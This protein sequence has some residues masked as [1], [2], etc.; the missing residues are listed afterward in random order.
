MR[1]RI[2]S[3]HVLA[4]IA[5]VLA[6]GGNAFAFHLGKNSVGSKQLKKNA[7]TTKKIKDQAI[8]AAKVKNGALTGTQINASTLDTVPTA[9]AANAANTANTA[10]TAA[11]ANSLA[12][13]ENWHLVGAPGEPGFQ[14]SWHN[15]GGTWA[16]AAF[17]KD[18]EGIVHLK[19]L[20]TGGTS[21]TVFQ[22]PPGYRSAE[23][24]YFPIECDGD[25]CT[26]SGDGFADVIGSNEP[27]EKAG[28]VSVIG[29]YASL[30]GIDFRAES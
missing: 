12:P 7:V 29:E 13:P 11:T 8:T 26:L 2:N 4:L 20:V 15:F 19:G 27:P 21:G 9:N 28:V 5:I 6:L 10:N 23:R 14:N 16:R 22:L 25:G 17:Y 30:S 1:A 24:L 18:H 3:A